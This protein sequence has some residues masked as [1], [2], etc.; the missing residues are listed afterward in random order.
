MTVPVAATTVLALAFTAMA[1]PALSEA[2][3]VDGHIVAIGDSYTSGEGVAPFEDSSDRE[4]VNEC[5]RS[6]LA[7]PVRLGESLGVPAESWACSGATTGDLSTAVVRTDHAPWDDP[8]LDVG[9]GPPLSALDRID[10]NTPFVALTVGG[11]DLGFSDIVSDC[12]LGQEPC[13]RH[14]AQVQQ[15][16]ADLEGSLRALFSD[17]GSRLSPRARVLVVGYPRVFPALPLADC[18]FIPLLP[19]GTFTVDEQTWANTKT[20][21]LNSVLRSEVERSNQPG[22]PT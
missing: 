21:D 14:D 5:H 12:L 18:D 9:D 4:G 22:G 3:P 1:V 2:P 7:Y 11:N 6:T 8:V 16:L 19:V 13:T 17:I 15:D 10:P 20:A